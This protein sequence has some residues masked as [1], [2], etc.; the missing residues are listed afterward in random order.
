MAQRLMGCCLGVQ[1]DE[2][3]EAQQ[4]QELAVIHIQ[5]GESYGEQGDGGDE[6]YFPFQGAYILTGQAFANEPIILR[7]V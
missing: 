5:E 1:I 6:G 3:S 7:G 4:V 2:E